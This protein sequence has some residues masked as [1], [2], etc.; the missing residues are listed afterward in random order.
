M[1]THHVAAGSTQGG[2]R[3]VSTHGVTVS[4]ELIYATSRAQHYRALFARRYRTQRLG[5][6]AA[7]EHA[8]GGCRY[9]TTHGVDHVDVHTEPGWRDGI[10]AWLH[11]CRRAAG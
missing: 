10:R 6:A 2:C 5:L 3:Y 4:Y 11:L 7:A 1:C 8:Y 9:V